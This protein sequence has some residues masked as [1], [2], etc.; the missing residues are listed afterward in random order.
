[1][2]TIPSLDPHD[3]IAFTTRQLIRALQVSPNTFYKYLRQS[4]IEPRR[5][6]R[7]YA[8][9]YS[10]TDAMTL[11]DLIYPPERLYKIIQKNTK[12]ITFK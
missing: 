10:Y 4:G 2:S 11:F 12:E 3:Q 8:K 5:K 6:R 1:M 9:Y 7:K